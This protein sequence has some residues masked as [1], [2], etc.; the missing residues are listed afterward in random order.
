MS[1]DFIP[2]ASSVL[3]EYNPR[4]PIELCQ[5][6]KRLHYVPGECPPL[7]SVTTHVGDM[8]FTAFIDPVPMSAL[9]DNIF[10]TDVSVHPV[11]KRG[12]GRPKTVVDPKAYKAQKAKEYRAKKK[13]K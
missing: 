6:C 7:R 5:R 4:M 2:L 8:R 12:R 13:T 11:A 3:L 9:T 10:R 1:V